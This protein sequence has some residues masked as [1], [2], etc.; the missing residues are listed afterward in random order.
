MKKSGIKRPTIHKWDLLKERLLY[1]K[2]HHDLNEEAAHRVGRNH[3]ISLSS[4]LE[5]VTK[6]QSVDALLLAQ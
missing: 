5:D 6:E 3:F 4:G 1:S 2:A